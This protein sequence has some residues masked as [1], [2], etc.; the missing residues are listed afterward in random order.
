LSS[1]KRPEERERLK[2]WY[3]V[4][5]SEDSWICNAHRMSVVGHEKPPEKLEHN[6]KRKEPEQVLIEIPV[7]KTVDREVEER[8]SVDFKQERESSAFQTSEWQSSARKIP[9]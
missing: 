2:E 9:P 8:L 6:R 4:E 5:F 3:K 7:D 1:L